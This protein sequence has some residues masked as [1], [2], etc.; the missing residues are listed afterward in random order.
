MPNDEKAA[1]K[2]LEGLNASDAPWLTPLS[3]SKPAVRPASKPS[4]KPAPKSTSDDAADQVERIAKR[5]KD[6][7]DRTRHLRGGSRSY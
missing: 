6:L 1:R 3:G 7:A 5:N 2:F 4:P